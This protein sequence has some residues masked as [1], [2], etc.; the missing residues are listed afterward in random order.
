M[1]LDTFLSQCKTNTRVLYRDTMFT[2]LLSIFQL[3]GWSR[4]FGPS[5]GIYF[6]QLVRFPCI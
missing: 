5:Y 4:S 6:S 2:S 1:D 3:F